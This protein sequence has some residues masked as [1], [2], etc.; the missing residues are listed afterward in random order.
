MGVAELLADGVQL[1][2]LGMGVVFV[3]LGLLV[4]VILLTAWLSKS[5]EGR[6]PA[7]APAAAPS[8]AAGNADA[9]LTA[10]ITAA[11]RRYRAS[12]RG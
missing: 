2:V 11:I 4:G 10:A 12:H 8:A 5:I 3:F 1:M 9:E 7:L 6:T